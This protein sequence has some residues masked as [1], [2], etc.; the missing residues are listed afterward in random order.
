LIDTVGA[1]MQ[2]I[3]AY[4][5]IGH[6]VPRLH[7]PIS[8]RGQDL[9]DDLLA[10]VEK[11][12]IP[13]AVG[14]GVRDLIVDDGAVRGVVVENAAGGTEKILAGKVILAVNGYAGNPD[15]VRRFCP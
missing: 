8:R 4:K 13:L 11:R 5:H 7:A 10:A 15:L 14:N 1:R 3:T 12:E 6:T 2:L 9:V